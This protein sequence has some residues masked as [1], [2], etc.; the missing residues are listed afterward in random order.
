MRFRYLSAAVALIVATAALVS[1]PALA[2]TTG[3]IEG[4]ITDTSGAPL[5]GATVEI[6]SP[7]L[8]GMRTGVTGAD[9]RFRFP[10]VPPGTY[11]VTATLSGFK[12]IER[13]A[14]KVNLDAVATV[15][16]KM[17]ISVSQEIVVTGEAPV[18]D[19][20]TNANGIN[21]RSDVV[22][23]LPL[24][25][26]YAAAVEI[27]PGVSR[28]TSDSQGRGQTYTIYG[29]TSIENQYLVDGVNT[30][31]VI[32]GFSGKAL[33]QEF[34]EEVQVKAGG[35]E[36]EYGRAMGGIVNVVTKS[37][38]NEFHG[39]AFG[40]FNSKGLTAE[41]K[42]D[43]V[44][45]E[46][47]IDD[48]QRNVQD[49]GVDL[50][51]FMMKDRVWFFG[52]YNRVNQNVDQ[53]LLKGSLG[54]QA[55]TPDNPNNTCLNGPQATA[56]ACTSANYPISFHSDLF[57]GKI[58]A[59]PTDSTTV[60]GTIFGDPEE[61]TGAIRNYTAVD[62][63]TQIGTRKIGATDFAFGAT[64]LFGT[65][66]L[67]DVR[68]SHHKDRYTVT[69]AGASS[70]RIIDSHLNPNNPTASNGFGSIRGFREFNESKRDAIKGQ[71]SLFLG[72]HEIKAGVDY[73]NNLTDSTD[74]YSGGGQLRIFACGGA[75]CSAGTPFVLPDGKPVYFGHEF[76]T[77]VA[78]KT[79][80][81]SGFLTGNTVSPR[82]YRLGFFAQDSW[83][84]MPNLTV[85]AGI[86]YD[87]EDIRK[88]DG[89]EVFN[90]QVLD[91]SGNVIQ[92]GGQPFKLKNEWQPR[93]GIAWDPMKDG[94]SKVSV[95][96][97][98]FYYALPTDLTV[99]SYAAKLDATVY[100]YN[101]SQEF[102]AGSPA[103]R[104]DP[105]VGRGATTQGGFAP[106][107]FQDNLKG[108]YQDEFALGFEKALDPTFSVG[109]RYTYRNLGRVIEDRC[110]FDSRYPESDGNTCV[111]INPGSD[112]P[113][114]TGAGVH[115]CDGRDYIPVPDNQSDFSDCT[116]PQTTNVTIPKAERKFH[117]LEL[118][119]KKRVSTQLWI[120]ASY[121][122][123]HLYGNYDGEASIGQTQ[124]P[125]N[126]QTDP[127]INAD[128][129]YPHFLT[130]AQGNLFLDRRHSFRFD[131]AYTAPFGLTV[132]LQTFLRSGAPISKYGYFN[133]G[134][135]AESNF[136]TPRGSGGRLPWDYELNLSLAYALKISSIT[137]TLF[138][139]GFNLI[140]KQNV[141]GVD[142]DCTIAPPL[143]NTT[144][145]GPGTVSD[146][147]VAT[148]NP[149]EGG[150]ANQ[151]Y[152]KT[153]WRGNPR[154][155]RLGARVSF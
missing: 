154:S 76:Y 97:G 15:P 96:Y 19:T 109:V 91:G 79:Q 112:S 42:A 80:L 3:S 72:A 100:N 58:T 99:R 139:Q 43:A 113:Y 128:Y 57:S 1:M 70:V 28:D 35:Y 122:W 25:R 63:L 140:N 102:A 86:R 49:F 148:N 119:V 107:P 142:Q 130:Y 141:I 8:L 30:T 77:T 110:D 127:G 11:T 118:V 121:L 74:L 106:E 41:P 155:L 89:T 105:N 114:A 82:A 69:G 39:D 23:K 50:G 88:Y 132:G 103:L 116:G 16:I 152:G 126:G 150:G 71:G 48:S 36:A 26:N 68:Y 31:N 135:F 65:G 125:G 32:R 45:D 38:G 27:N 131:G 6:K 54:L 83:K 18:V 53:T 7:S 120:Q 134:Y 55:P 84:V 138:A 9:G 94:S 33:S 66:G 34:I 98:R 46:Y 123:S 21:I 5:P 73:E 52:A 101:P 133:G 62:P 24:G 51:G 22:Q 67:L 124:S 104:Q 20:T 108:I 44:T 87:Q 4:S 147:S 14:V 47:Y 143:V 95:S 90:D 92:Q 151:D 61:R 40:Y 136:V 12:K 59:R 93:I 145:S 60:V 81:D 78:D 29:A 75:R 37:G 146:C 56:D 13:T 64:Q 17:E 115:T 144:D 85:N 153:I 137:V 10:A 129:D 117:G 2:Q 111:I 149:S